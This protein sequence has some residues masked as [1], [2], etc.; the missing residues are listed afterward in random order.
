MI[1]AT[2]P[3]VGRLR[4][5][6]PRR[7]RAARVTLAPPATSAAE[8]A[9]GSPPGALVGPAQVLG[10]DEVGRAVVRLGDALG[11]QVAAEWA[12]PFRYSPAPGDVL[13]TIGRGARHWVIGVAAGRGRSELAF[14]GDAALTAGGAL[15]LRADRGLRLVGSVVTLRGGRVEV[16]VRALEEQL[17]SAARLVRGAL[18]EVAGKALRLIDGED[19]VVARDVTI[20]AQESARLDGDL[21]QVS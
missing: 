17:G 16:L 8:A 10:V 7:A 9:P 4:A 3:L 1:D 5:R 2:L 20:L 21:L 14:R 6:W 12:L 13:W 19:C 11:T 18:E 15:H